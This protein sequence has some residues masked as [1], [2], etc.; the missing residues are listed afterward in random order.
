MMNRLPRSGLRSAR[1]VEALSF[2]IFTPHS[3]GSAARLLS[4]SH[5]EG[6]FPAMVTKP[7]ATAARRKP[8]RTGPGLRIFRHAMATSLVAAALCTLSGCEKPPTFDELIHGKKKDATPPAPVAKQAAETPKAAP[9]AAPQT[10]EPPKKTAQEVLAQFNSTQ[11]YRRTNEQLAELASLPEARDQITVLELQGSTIN[12]A[13]LA[14]LPKFDKVEKLNIGTLNY[15]N[16][17]LANVAKM[18]NVTTLVMSKGA[19]KD[20][21]TDA[22]MAHISQMKQL[23]ELYVDQAKFSTAGIAE[24][25]KMTQLEKLSV[26]MISQ[27]TDEHL[28]MLAPLV[29]LKYLDLTGS[30]V[31]DNGLKYLL[32]F[33][34]LEDLRMAKMQAVRGAGLD[35][36]VTKRHGLRKLTNLTMYD[37]PYLNIQAYVGISNIKTL[38]VLDVGAANCTNAA[39]EAMPHLRNLEVLSVHDNESLSD[40]GMISYFSK[41]KKLKSIYFGNNKLISDASIPAFA[42]VKTLER[43]TLLQTAVTPTGAQKLKSKLK[44]CKVNYNGTM[45]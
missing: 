19:Q 35:D 4:A 41:L 6:V 39:F 29:N 5:H 28:E 2:A 24:I 40:D 20:K 26:G 21:N 45:L 32:P 8:N 22:G 17:A 12:D 11:T 25:A 33:T 38:V 43:I 14:V 30:Y 37:N 44:N 13:G 36:L 1:S 27:F 16:Q 10:P 31:T 42:K 15:S 3:F 18:K 7:R 34:E 9:Q 23:V